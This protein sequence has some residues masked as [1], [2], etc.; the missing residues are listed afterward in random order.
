MDGQG[1]EGRPA[2]LPWF[3]AY[4][5][6]LCVLYLGVVAF[7]L[8]FCFADPAD[9]EMPRAAAVVVGTLI[10]VMGVTLF[11]ASSIPLLL[12]PRPWLWT[13]GLVLICLGMTSACFLPICIPLL[14]RWIK[15]E[16]KRYFGRE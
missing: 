7:S 14:L 3:H 13:Y 10:L 12:R 15:P 6:L 4:C 5:W 9:L 11:V 16:V 8:V 2:V 1:G